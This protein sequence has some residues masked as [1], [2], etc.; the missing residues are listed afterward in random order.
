MTELNRDIVRKTRAVHMGREIYI[1]ASPRTLYIREKSQREWMPVPWEAALHV[2]YKMRV[3]AE[4]RQK[5]Q[6]AS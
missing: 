4:Q 2:A 3:A 6:R 1:K 5:K